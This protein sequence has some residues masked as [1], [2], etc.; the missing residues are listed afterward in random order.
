M[1][2]ADRKLTYEPG[3]VGRPWLIAVSTGA[4]ILVAAI[5][6]VAI[7]FYYLPFAREKP[8]SLSKFPEPGLQV[9]PSADLAALEQEQRARLNQT[10]W[11]DEEAGRLTIPIEAAMKAIVKRGGDAFAPLPTAEAANSAERPAAAHPPAD[12][13]SNPGSGEPEPM[14]APQ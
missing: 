2:E 7:Y 6:M 10:R 13:P 8:I 9:D 12:R 14:E 11:Q 1:A 5:C 3:E 4:V